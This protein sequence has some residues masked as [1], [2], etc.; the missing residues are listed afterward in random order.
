[1]PT[2]FTVFSLG[3]QADIDSD[4]ATGS[5][6]NDAENADDLTGLS[7]G[8]PGN[9]LFE[10]AVTFS[11]GSGGFTGGT[12]NVYDQDN[13]P[14]ENFRI[15]GG[16][17]QRFDAAAIYNA[18]IT[19][20]DGTTATITAVIFQDVDGN[21]YWAP[22]FA[23]NADQA[24]LEAKPIQSLTL[25]SVSGDTFS[26]LAGDRENWDFLTC[27]VS[28]TMIETDRGS[29]QIETLQ[30]GDLVATQ[31][32]GYQ[33]IRW[34][35]CSRVKAH[36]K[37]APIRI[38][39]GALGPGCPSEDLLVSRQHRML[40]RSKV[41]ERMFGAKE[42]LVPAIKLTALPGIF[43]DD[44]QEQVTYLHL[45]TDQHDVIYAAGAPSETMLNGPHAKEALD[46]A[47]KEELMAIFPDLWDTPPLPARPIQ[48]DKRIA[49]LLMRHQKNKIP[50]VAQGMKESVTTLCE[51]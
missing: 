27:Y 36:G 30:I 20:T 35:G 44:S 50:H 15:N 2:T 40:L 3:V 46:D 37:L 1:M 28:G 5:G 19:Y 7:F 33:P 32:H 51:T 41:C 22:E 12:N 34:I 47:A 18:T 26:G 9:P 11:T 25:D 48:R 23:P 13:N 16:P 45:M 21:T 17:N 38:M 10:S 4:P 43:I 49:K 8:G 31:D 6:D 24:A 42:I 14:G 29:R 39:A